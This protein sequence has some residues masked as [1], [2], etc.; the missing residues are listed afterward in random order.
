ML[1]MQPTRFCQLALSVALTL[2]M[3]LLLRRWDDTAASL[4][5]L[6]R[7]SEMP[8]MITLDQL[9]CRQAS[10]HTRRRN[11]NNNNNNALWLFNSCFLVATL[12]ASECEPLVV[13][14]ASEQ[15]TSKEQQ[16]KDNT[17]SARAS[18]LKG[19]LAHNTVSAGMS[20]WRMSSSA[21]IPWRRIHTHTLS[22]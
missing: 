14:A 2:L 18:E 6:V 7:M 1:V 22:V 4:L 15:T 8:M 19:Q 17:A 10:E 21:P 11:N 20:E 5:M 16:A 12:Q 13:V 3:L 9:E